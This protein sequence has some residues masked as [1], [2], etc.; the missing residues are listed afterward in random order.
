MIEIDP[1]AAH[2]R[3][4]NGSLANFPHNLKNMPP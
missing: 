1:K 2:H 3:R 4:L